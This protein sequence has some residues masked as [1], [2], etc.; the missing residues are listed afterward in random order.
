MVLLGRRSRRHRALIGKRVSVGC[1][2]VY[3]V[4]VGSHVEGLLGIRDY[5]TIT[6]A[7]FSLPRVIRIE[8]CLLHLWGSIYHHNPNDNHHNND[9]YCNN[10]H[11]NCNNLNNS[12]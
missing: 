5:S 7:F 9:Y 11:G 12:T 8:R 3:V 1:S 2:R 4:V 6:T 10:N